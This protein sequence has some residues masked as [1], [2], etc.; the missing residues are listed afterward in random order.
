MVDGQLKSKTDP[1]ITRLTALSDYFESA[2]S[3]LSCVCLGSV[4]VCVCL[5]IAAVIQVNGDVRV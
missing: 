5:T 4:C 2:G 3:F 1:G